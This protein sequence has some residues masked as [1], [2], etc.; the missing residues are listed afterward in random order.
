MHSICFE[1][2]PLTIRWYGVFMALGFTGG[3]LN[4]I[5]LGRRRGHDTQFCSDLMFWVMVSGIVGARLAYVLENWSEYASDPITILRIDQGGLIFYGGFVLAGA[6]IVYFAKKK[7]E[8][9]MPLFDFVIT[10]VPLAHALGR[11]G[12]FLNGCCFGRCTSLPIG[13]HFPKPS[14][15]FWEHIKNGVIEKTATVSAA[16]HPVQL[17]ESAYNFMIYIVLILIYRRT[18]RVGI[19]SAV[20]L[21]LYS[22]GRFTL[23]FF[24]GDRGERVA[25]GE[26]SIG[27]F[28]SIPIFLL[29]FGLFLFLVLGRKWHGA[30]SGDN[31]SLDA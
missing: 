3:L 10:S 7:R 18:K 26:L 12:C 20:Y 4:W 16:V 1:I 19:V 5:W 23:E 25:V 30:G 14:A 31:P 2:G 28:V 8:P 15:P 24:R 22:L 29:G 21:M 9:V 17:Y 27:Q 11:I 6:A 13:V